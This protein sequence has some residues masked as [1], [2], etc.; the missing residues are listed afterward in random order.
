[1]RLFISF[2]LALTISAWNGH[3]VCADEAAVKQMINDYARAFN[4]KQ[5]DQVMSFWTK[6]G[7][8]IDRDTG[9]RTEGR[10]A[11]RQDI[12]EALEQRPGTRIF[13]RIERL[14]LIKPDVA[15]VEGQVT[16]STPDEA[17]SV[18]VFSAILV[19]QDNRW[20]IEE[21]EEVALPQPASSYDA[22]QELE[23]LVGNW[24]DDAE[25]ARVD[26]VFRWTANQAFLLR[27]YAVKADDGVAQQGTQIIGWD[28]RSG[29]IRS[30]SFNSDGS[31]GDGTWT[32]SGSDWLIRSS[33]TLPDGQAASGT[34]VL[35]RVSDGEMTLKLI[36]HDIEG[37]PQPASASVRVVRA[38][39]GDETSGETADAE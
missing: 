14:R 28:P 2:G 18:N 25:D 8:H 3:V 37:Q 36:G 32:K 31:F 22:L 9:E 29:E 27:S 35:S 17:A 34:Y 23:W 4:A 24:V 26:T 15:S 7:I 30:W 6:S 39:E 11:I 38:A 5:I 21:I 12:S 16:V 19:N 33:Q 10:E 13:G 1:M 20:M